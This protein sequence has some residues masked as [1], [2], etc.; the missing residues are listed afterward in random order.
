MELSDDELTALHGM[1]EEWVQSSE[2]WIDEDL[3]LI[4]I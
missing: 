4:H 1:L 3:S 2:F